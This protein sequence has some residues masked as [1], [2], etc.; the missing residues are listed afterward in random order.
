MSVEVS[1]ETLLHC[2]TCARYRT[3][4]TPPCPDGHGADCPERLCT[5]CGTALLLAPA[6]AHHDA[7]RERPVRRAA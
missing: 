5:A 7:P 2:P 1:E 4:E 6:A 3:V